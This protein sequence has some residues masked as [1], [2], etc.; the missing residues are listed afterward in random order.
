VP[1]DRE[2]RELSTSSYDEKR[3]FDST[4]E[5]PGEHVAGDVD[6]VTAP[7]G[8]AY[9]IQQH[10]AT[11]LH[12]DVRLEMISGDT[13]VLVSWAVPKGLPRKRGDRHLAIRTEDHPM[14]YATFSGTIPEG[15]YGGG[16]VRIFDHGTYEM[17]DRTE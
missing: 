3:S 6:P 8:D 11:A 13:P 12:H 1:P 5:P 16:V 4:P 10:H 14:G 9:V 7:V 2:A 17:E 15:E